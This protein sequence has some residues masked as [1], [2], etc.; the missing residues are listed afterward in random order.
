MFLNK[1]FYS[2]NFNSLLWWFT[3]LI[4]YKHFL[5]KDKKNSKKLIPEPSELKKKLCLWLSNR[6]LLGYC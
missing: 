3:P 1:I 4:Y 5:L 6:T 2:K